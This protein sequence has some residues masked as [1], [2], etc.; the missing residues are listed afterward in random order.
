MMLRRAFLSVVTDD[1]VA[2]RDWYVRLFGYEVT[3]DSDWFVQLQSPNEPLLE[4]GLLRRDHEVTPDATRASAGA[5][6][7]TIVVD[8]VDDVYDHAMRLGVTIVEPPRDL[9]YGQRRM[10]ILD[11]NGMVLD[12]SSECVPDSTW[13]A[14]L[15]SPDAEPD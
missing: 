9:F 6:M 7:L 14:S 1:V 2:S 12:V 4:L 13:L 5:A 11:P 3:F 15:S 8:E 10:V